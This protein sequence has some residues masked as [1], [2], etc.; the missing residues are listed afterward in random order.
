VPGI[1]ELPLV[2][3]FSQYTF[4]AGSRP[5]WLVGDATFEPGASRVTFPVF[6]VSGGQFRGDRLATRERVGQVTL[7]SRSCNNLAFRYDYSRIGLG[8]GNRRLQRLYSLETAGYDCRD[9]EA[10]V[11]ANREP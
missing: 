8:V 7:T 4:D 10:R 9:H 5:M 2:V 11:A 6:R 3:F 1:P